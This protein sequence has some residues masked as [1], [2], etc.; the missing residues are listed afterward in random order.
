[1]KSSQHFHADFSKV[2]RQV[3]YASAPGSVAAD[4]NLLPY[5]KVQRPKW[6]L[7]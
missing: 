4:F 3:L 2:A 1:V 7:H 6:P 5:R